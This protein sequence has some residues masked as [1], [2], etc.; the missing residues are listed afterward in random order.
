[1]AEYFTKIE[2]LFQQFRNNQSI[3][4]SSENV[5]TT[6]EGNDGTQYLRIFQPDR[7]VD[8]TIKNVNNIYKDEDDFTTGLAE[9]SGSRDFR[10]Q[11]GTITLNNRDYWEN[12]NFND[13]NFTPYLSEPRLIMETDPIIDGNED[14]I[15]TNNVRQNSVNFQYSIDQVKLTK[16]P[17]F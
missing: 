11:L 6:V 13:N 1:M 16:A 17:N 4:G 15:I 12:V 2:D 7:G 9:E 10:K 3:G 8:V 5:N 14:E